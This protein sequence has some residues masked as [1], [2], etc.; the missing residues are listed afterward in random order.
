MAPHTL[1]FYH[2]SLCPLRACIADLRRRAASGLPHGRS[3]ERSGGPR[4]LLVI[5]RCG[6]LRVSLLPLVERVLADPQP[7][8]NLRYRIAPLGD[9]KDRVPLEVLGEVRF[10]HRGLLASKLGKKASRNLGAVQFSTLAEARSAITSW[11]EDY[12]HHRPHSALGKMPP[13]E[14]EMKVT[15]E[16]QAAQGQ[17]RNS[18]LPLRPEEKR[19]SGQCKA[20]CEPIDEIIPYQ[21]CDNENETLSD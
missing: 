2:S 15:L 13:A 12:N 6:R 17:K 20:K 4:G 11:K 3:S 7:R 21:N 9:L 1:G 19:V 18:G 8:R 16:R 5:A 14:F 10:A